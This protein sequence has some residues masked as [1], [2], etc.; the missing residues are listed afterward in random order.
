MAESVLRKKK[1]GLKIEAKQ[2]WFDW[3]DHVW[4]PY[5]APLEWNQYKC[6]NL[7]IGQS[8]STYN[9]SSCLTRQRK[10]RKDALCGWCISRNK[11]CWHI[12]LGISHYGPIFTNLLWCKASFCFFWQTASSWPK[13]WNVLRKRQGLKSKARPNRYWTNKSSIMLNVLTLVFS[14]LPAHSSI[15]F[16]INLDMNINKKLFADD[17]PSRDWCCDRKHIFSSVSGRVV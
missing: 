15:S 16:Q 10:Q 12:I 4:I 9:N 6:M 5:L 3:F 1:H 7:F 2:N 11:R 14:E 13:L 8:R 17:E